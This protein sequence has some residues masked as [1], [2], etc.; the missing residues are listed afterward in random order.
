MPGGAVAEILDVLLDN[1][2]LHGRGMVR[3][4]V[5]DLDDALAFDVPDE[6]EVSGDTARRFD[7]GHTGSGAGT[8]I[9]LARDLAVSLGGRL[10][11]RGT[12]ATFTLLL[13]VHRDQP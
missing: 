11:T 2:R 1:A 10:L 7:R 3:V 9:G 6:G 13:P 4:R 12:P 5:R 8:G